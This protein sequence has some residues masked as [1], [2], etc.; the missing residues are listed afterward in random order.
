MSYI[1][2]NIYGAAKSVDRQE[3][4]NLIRE[5][6]KINPDQTVVISADKD[7]RYKKVMQ[8]M[9]LLQQSQ[10]RRIGLLAVPKR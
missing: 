6:Q 3:L 2:R 7:V 8:V 10:V 4:L 1:D 5:K 9:D